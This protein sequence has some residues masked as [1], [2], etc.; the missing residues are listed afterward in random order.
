MSRLTDLMGEARRIAA[1]L[2]DPGVSGDQRRALV[3]L[4]TEVRAAIVEA[5]IDDQRRALVARADAARTSAGETVRVHP[6]AHV[7]ACPAPGTMT[8]T[9][10]EVEAHRSG[11]IWHLDA[12][13]PVPSW[14]P[15]TGRIISTSPAELAAARAEREAEL[16][17]GEASE[18]AARHA[19]R[20]A[21][22]R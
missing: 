11:G 18:R 21:V 5:S 8:V 14:W 4:D 22:L 15:R 20:N 19:S 3:D 13:Q 6:G 12:D 2:S 10:A 17:A 9:R 1:L 16:L 7:G